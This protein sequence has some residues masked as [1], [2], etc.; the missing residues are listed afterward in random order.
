MKRAVLR[1]M[2]LL[3]AGA[4]VN[5]AVAWGCAIVLFPAGVEPPQSRGNWIEQYSWNVERRHLF[6]ASELHSFRLRNP[7]QRPFN[8]AENPVEI[9]LP[10]SDLA[11]PTAEFQN[12][13]HADVNQLSAIAR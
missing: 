8:T 11:T 6:G 5:V 10:G 13:I 7:N 12:R 2:L 9:C 3:V 4:I 1:V